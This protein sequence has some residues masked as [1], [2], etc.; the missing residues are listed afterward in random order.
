MPNLPGTVW[1]KQVPFFGA[2][3]QWVQLGNV[4]TGAPGAA[5]PQGI[6][7]QQ[8]P[9][10]TSVVGPQ[11]D[12]GSVN[13]AGLRGS[14]CQGRLTLNSAN[15][16]ATTD[17]TGKATLYFVPFINDGGAQSTSGNIVTYN[18]AS[19]NSFSFGA[20]S[21]SVSGLISGKNYDVFAYVASNILNLTI[22]PAWTSDTART[23]ALGVQNGVLVNGVAYAAGACSIGQGLWVGTVRMSGAGVCEDSVAQRF[24]WNAYNRVQRKLLARNTANTNWT[25]TTAA[26]RPSNNST[27]VGQQR[28]QWVTGAQVEPLFARAHSVAYNAS[29][30]FYSAGIGIDSTTVNSSDCSGGFR[31]PVV[32]DYT[33]YPGLG[34]HYA[35]RLET[36]RATGTSSWYDNSDSTVVGEIQSALWGFLYA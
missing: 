23:D 8:G 29:E 2:P 31:L 30:P 28:F 13:G 17:Q 35:Q 34:F 11:G 1:Q 20:I 3:P 27:V 7:G 15:A 19:W 21:L 12:P 9:P 14:I 6:P 4:A 25:Y 26:W 10:G 24:V 18:G 22:G 32:A 33:G 5:G 36:S 16:I